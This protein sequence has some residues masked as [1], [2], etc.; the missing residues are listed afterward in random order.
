MLL[1]SVLVSKSEE[2]VHTVE[3]EDTADLHAA[4]KAKRMT[5]TVG[6]VMQCRSATT[7]EPPKTIPN[8]HRRQKSVKGTV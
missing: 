6:L 4:E 2:T 7:L 3:E 8:E 5:D 1:S